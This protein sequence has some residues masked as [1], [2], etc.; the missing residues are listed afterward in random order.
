MVSTDTYDDESSINYQS[1]SMSLMEF[2]R[3]F[4]RFPISEGEREGSAQK[5]NATGTQTNIV[6]CYE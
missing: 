5:P 2:H 4:I 3:V 1:L 6:T